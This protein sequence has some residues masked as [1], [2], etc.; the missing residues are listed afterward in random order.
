MPEW[1]SPRA[2]LLASVPFLLLIQSRPSAGWLY[3]ALGL[4]VASSAFAIVH[5]WGP[6]ALMPASVAGGFVLWGLGL[7]IWRWKPA[8]CRRLRLVEGLGYEFPPYHAA[9]ALGVTALGLWLDPSLSWPGLV[10]VGRL[11][12]GGGGG[13]LAADAQALSRIAGGWTGSPA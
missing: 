8:L 6:D 12:A 10:V 2:L 4:M 13:P 5:R 1:D 3:P 9:M 11:G 7:A